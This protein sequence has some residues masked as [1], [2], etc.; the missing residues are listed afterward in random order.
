MA[1]VVQGADAPRDV[2]GVGFGPS[3]LALAVALA[4]RDGPS[5]T[6][7][8]R[9]PRF[10]WHRG[11]LIDG[12]TM[13]VSFLKD[14]VSMRNPTSPHSFVSYLH[15]RGRMPEFVNAKTLYPLRVE[16]HDYLEWVA[17]HF[18]D[19]VS[20]GSEI[21]A[22]EPVAEGGVVGHL[23]VVAR[24][25][26]RT[27]TTRARNVV[28]ATGLEPRLPD[29]VSGGE[30][31]WHSGELLHRVPWLRE[32][33]VRKVVVVG[34]GQSAAE[35]T[36]YLHRTLPGAEVVAVFSRFGYS[37]ADDTPFV[38][39]V[40]DPDSVDL[41]YGSPPSVR[42]ALL[43]HHGNTNYSVVDADL[44][45]E[46]YRRRY[47]ERVTGSSRLRVVNVSRVRS[48]S[49]RSDGVAVQVEYLPTGVVGTLVADAV[50]CAT[51]YRPADPTPLL[52]GLAKLDGA[53]RPVLDR[54]HRVVTSG[55]VRAGIYLQGAVTEPTHG[56]SAGL[57]S[58]TAVRAGEIVRAILDEGR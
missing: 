20:Y 39:E 9:Q 8:E 33:R 30:R 45:L 6:F 53:G 21:T 22:L 37:V 15:A 11:M 38:N 29:G 24:R 23:D 42:Q 44:S 14:L 58:T 31:V 3:N 18:A 57:L 56:L 16:F 51:G 26:G 49:E 12:A 36:E 5:S 7:F 10:G 1:A 25:D 48:V 46:L 40:F 27:T 43:A 28:V 17:G 2:V 50:V 13:Q 47:Q 55:S 4:E 54:D 35:V 19:S 41:F 52:R 32:R 34:A